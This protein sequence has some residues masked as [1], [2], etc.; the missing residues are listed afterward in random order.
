MLQRAPQI[1]HNC[2]VFC[3]NSYLSLLDC[4]ARATS[5][6]TIRRSLRIGFASFA[7]RYAKPSEEEASDIIETRSRERRMRR[8]AHYERVP[9]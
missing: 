9:D 2:R 7:T 6:E 1:R 5:R 8:K 4:E 3:L